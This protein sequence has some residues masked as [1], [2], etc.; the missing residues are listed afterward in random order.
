MVLCV[1]ARCVRQRD[2]G[3]TGPSTLGDRALPSRWEARARLGRRPR[4]YLGWVASAPRLGL[5][6]LVLCPP[7]R[8]R[9]SPYRGGGFFPLGAVCRRRAATSWCNS[10][11]ASPAPPVK[12]ASPS[13][14]GRRHAR[15][16]APAPRQPDDDHA[17]VVL[18][19]CR[20]VRASQTGSSRRA[21][22]RVRRAGTY[23]LVLSTTTLGV[24]GW[25]RLGEE[26]HP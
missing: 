25:G 11:S 26:D 3:A 21:T 15:N 16:L 12:R 23:Q 14:R 19:R 18:S 17:K 1:G 7:C 10:S 20:Y 5:P 22:R 24:C 8:R 6:H 2:T 4:P 13:R 9:R